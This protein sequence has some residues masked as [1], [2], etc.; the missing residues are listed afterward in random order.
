M[1]DFLKNDSLTDAIPPAEVCDGFSRSDG[2]D[3]LCSKEALWNPHF[4]DKYWSFMDVFHW[5]QCRE[6]EKPKSQPSSCYLGRRWKA[7]QHF[8][9]SIQDI[10]TFLDDL[11][12]NWYEIAEQAFELIIR[13][14]K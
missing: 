5:F 6:D 10:L 3:Q 1:W 13:E 9:D 4:S 7:Y 2:K 11:F 8:L 14:C 12:A